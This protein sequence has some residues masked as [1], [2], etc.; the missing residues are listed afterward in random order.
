MLRYFRINDPYRL[1]A[2][3]VL[4]LILFLP[5][6][7]D[8]PDLTYPELKSIV[9]GEKIREGFTPYTQLIDTS[10]P[11]TDWVSGASHFLFGDSLTGRHIFAF[12]L[13]FLQATML[14]LIFIDKKVFP[15][16]TYVP[17][18]IFAI[19]CTFSFDML[20]L[21]GEL[22]GSFFLILSLNSL[23]KQLEFKEQRNEN[24]FNAGLFI[25]IASLFSFSY[26]VFIVAALIILGLYSRAN[27]GKFLLALL[28]FLMP[29]L[30][31]VSIYYLN[32][33]T[34]QLW[35]YF[36]LPNLKGGM[37]YFSFGALMKT[38]ALP[39]AFLITSLVI[40]TRDSRFTKYQSQLV[41]A[42]FF[43]MIFSI[44]QIAYS[45]D[46]R[47]QSM[48]SLFPA[49]T[50]YISHMLL[51]IRR[52]KF[53]EISLLVLLLG[54][55]A[56]ALMSR[57]KT[58]AVADYSAMIVDVSKRTVPAGKKIVVLDDSP[59]SYVGNALATPFLDWSLSKEIFESPDFY[60]NQLQVYHG[61]KADPPD[62]VVDPSNLMAPFL[63]RMP[64]LR[65]KYKR[66]E[67]GYTRISN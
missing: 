38:L 48:I 6:L 61:F 28:G 32:G 21:T 30:L 22:V 31:L 66:T 27:T 10:A 43:W 4:Q 47:P 63:N 54:V 16:S 18:L 65:V 12:F 15:D 11:L 44:V 58:I 55:P 51:M 7:I 50:F 33:G 26:S 42:M 37:G 34:A 52:R 13:L 67:T 24:V 60:E 9:V 35:N 49:L 56:I 23:F 1:L 62:L 53:A 39:I 40:L 5:V 14:G 36:Y 3:L 57:Y 19:L 17:A 59:A 45:N 29:N 46:M 41:Q 25:G 8:V 64:D 2:I 20:A